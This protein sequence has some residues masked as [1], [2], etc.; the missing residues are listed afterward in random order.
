MDATALLLALVM[1]VAGVAIGWLLAHRRGDASTQASRLEA[2]A[3]R[4]ELDA[5]RAAGARTEELLRRNDEQL[6]ELFGAHAAEALQRNAE[7]LVQLAKTQ[8][9]SS[10]TAASG[11]LAQ[12]Q[13]AIE[14]MV[15]PLR[16]S[17]A[18]VHEQLAEVEKGRSSSDAALRAQMKSMS[19]T[20][21]QLNTQTAQLVTALRA[22]QTRGRWGEMQ[23]ERVVEAAGM[24]EHVDFLTQVSATSD[25]GA[26]LRPDM[27]VKLT[28]GKVVVVD[29]KVPFAAYLEAMEAA[30]ERTRA[31][32][33]K[34]HARHL[35][36]HIDSLS[37]KSYA[38]LFDCTPEFVV[39]FVP[40]DA[41]LDAALREDATLLE[42]AFAKDVV[43]ATPSTLV[44]LLRTIA[45]TWRQ[46]A[47]AANAKQVHEL[48]RDLY[49][50]LSTLGN[51]FDKLGRNLRG[52]VGS[53]NDAIG[54]MERMVLSKAR[55]MNDLGVV[56][57]GAELPRLEPLIDA[58]PRPTTAPE[59]AGSGG[60][61]DSRVISLPPQPQLPTGLG[62]DE[63]VSS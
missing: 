43:L 57:A 13:Q 46:E 24:T 60:K 49:K 33:M 18:K 37:A 32:R 16:D 8:L 23:L 53:Y 14:A 44:A 25:E 50:R 34:A 27:V 62:D 39:C 20:S 30:D 51:H 4:A 40:A 36:T 17:L 47:L 10:T 56:D 42:H 21:F 48:G 59:L 26:R 61:H 31:D 45:Y 38:H 1:L 22:P 28:G 12:R 55:Q 3:L 11:D 9:A 2:A 52:A 63:R 15:A 5:Q 6:R 58:I 29:S 7:Q 19:E 54:S 35:R 41:F